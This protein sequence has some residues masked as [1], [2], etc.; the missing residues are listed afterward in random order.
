MMFFLLTGTNSAVINFA[1][2]G[3]KN[4]VNIALNNNNEE[5][6]EEESKNL[7]EEDCDQFAYDHRW[8][9]KEKSTD[10]FLHFIYQEVLFHNLELEVVV[11]PPK[12]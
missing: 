1:Y 7:A 4:F 8:A 12:A 10:S 11:P 6:S 3:Y 9:S 5:H 2:S